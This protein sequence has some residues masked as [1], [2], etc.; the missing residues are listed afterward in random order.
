MPIVN[1]LVIS[2]L[3]VFQTATPLGDTSSFEVDLAN[4]ASSFNDVSCI[5][6]VDSYERTH[7]SDKERYIEYILD[8][9][10]RYYPDL[11]P[12]IVQA[13]METESQYIPTVQS[14]AGAVGLMQV[15]PKWHS[16]RMEKYGLDDIWDPYTNVVV[17]ADFLNES[18]KRYGNYR[19][20]LYAYN[21][22][23]SYVNYVL[24]LA[25]EI[26]QGE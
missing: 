9:C 13:V 1:K 10:E 7:P 4:T 25:E 26:R 23:T 24:A 15:I 2:L 5:T 6:S 12:V 18:L 16:W 19:G 17:G 11:D 8:V 14:C 22:S 21:N 20:A 3:L